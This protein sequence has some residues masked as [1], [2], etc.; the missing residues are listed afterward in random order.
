MNIKF[1]QSQMYNLFSKYLGEASIYLNFDGSKKNQTQ[2]KCC[3]NNCTSILKNKKKLEINYDKCIYHCWVCGISGRLDKLAQRLF[4]GDDI[5]DFQHWFETYVGSFKYNSAL[6]SS[7]NDTYSYSIQQ[8]NLMLPDYIIPIKDIPQDNIIGKSAI[9]YL[10]RRGVIDIAN[11]YDLFYCY[12]GQYSGRI[13]IPSYDLEGNLNYYVTRDLLD[14]SGRHYDDAKVERS[15]IVFCENKLDYESN[16]VLVEG[17]F[18]YL[19]LDGHNRTALLGSAISANHKLFY[20][21]L[22]NQNTVTIYLDQDAHHK[23]L[24]IAKL[25]LS[26]GIQCRIINDTEHKDPGCTPR[27]RISELI[28]DMEQFPFITNKSDFLQY[29]IHNIGI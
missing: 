7:G 27:E 4:I 26:Y 13:I 28:N 25:F 14:G 6:T 21:L 20:K 22:T 17:A 16:V 9:N 8:H 18:D 12:S 2:Y 29:K 1:L 24:N 15:S 23:A 3:N 11:D 5:K 19:Q 10:T